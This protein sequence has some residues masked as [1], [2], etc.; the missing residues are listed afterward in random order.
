MK[1]AKERLLEIKNLII[2]FY[3]YRGIVKAV[4]VDNLVLYKG[5]SFGLVGET[6]CGKTVT[7]LSILRLISNPGI[8]E[9]G[10]IIFNGEDL[11][12][13][14]EQNMREIRGKAISMVFQD[15]MSSLNPV[16]TIGDQATRVI[17]IHQ[18]VGKKEARER[19]IR[20]LELVRLPDPRKIMGVYP[21]ELSAGM[22]Q[23]VMI[24]MALSCNPD[25]LIADESTSALDVTVQAQILKLMREL[26]EKISASILFVTHN[27]SVVAQTCERVAVMYAGNVVEVGKVRE[28]FKNPRHPYTI[29]LMD[30]IPKLG[31]KAKELRGIE[32]MVPDMINPPSGCRFHPRCPHTMNVCKTQ[33]P[34]MIEI[35]DGHLVSCFLYGESRQV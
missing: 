26:K 23:R 31:E 29:G 13:K 9:R 15:P 16:F 35:E 12:K 8:I 11:L 33:K 3:S 27:L 1:N 21:H 25:L 4:D 28:M 17:K 10:E 5:E 18:N 34:K 20:I 22:R 24:A 30:S 14:S 32:G 7:A 6:G 2:S 19:A